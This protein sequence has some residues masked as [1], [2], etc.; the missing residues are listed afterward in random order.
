MLSEFFYGKE[1]NKRL[2]P[3]EAVAYGATIQAAIQMGE[4]SEDVVLLDVCPFSLGIA[5]V[6]KNNIEDE[7]LHM[8]KIINKGSKLPCKKVD[9]FNPACDYST[10]ILIQ[11][12]EGENELVKNNYPL[13]KFEL[14]NLPKKKKEEVK[15]EV[16]FELNEDSILTVT[17]VEKENNSKNSIVIIN[18]RGGLSQNEIEKAKQEQDSTDE[19]KDLGPAM[20]I[21]KNYKY[22]INNLFNKVNKSTIAEEQYKLLKVLERTI[23]N[24]IQTFN[25][26]IS[27]NYTYKQK[28]HYY[29]TYLFNAYSASLNF[30]S[31]IDIET[32]EDIIEKVQNYLNIYEYSGTSYASSLVKIFKDNDDDIFGKFITQVLGYYSQR[33][34]T[35][36]GNNDKK[37]AKHY[38][39][40]AL[41]LE[42]K[43]SL[44]KRLS[45]NIFLSDKLTPI[46][47]NCK[48]FLNTLKADS[49]EKYCQ[50]FSKNIL[51]KEEELQTEE[52]K[53]DM[54][55]RFKDALYYLQ[56]PKNRHDK[57]LKAIYIA[58]IVKI[59]YI[60][61]HSNNYDVL[62][63][64]IEECIDLKSSAPQG[65][66]APILQWFNELCTIKEL[67]ES[68]QEKTKNNPLQAEKMIKEKIK[69]I[70]DEIEEKFK[71]GKIKFLYYILTEHKPIGL[72]KD[73]MFQNAK[74][75]ENAY[76]I[77]EK[78]F[79]KKLR[80]LYS[81][82][83]YKGNK[84]E[85]QKT[86]AI[87]QEISM[88]LNDL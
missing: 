14:I 25:E 8:S 20:I 71:Q 32:K 3:D 13:G 85:E 31:Y 40:E 66:E 39:E 74:E 30:K 23:E 12:Y 5:V 56:N 87:M 76:E 53:I 9:I 57:L 86:H 15:I 41:L 42:K 51:I 77:D 75:L 83:R 67:I 47:D 26:D 49:I 48:E 7:N 61:F 65:C 46:I 29:L 16:T 79:M 52:E 73:L 78:K 68:E 44:S 18:D 34:T 28:M 6:N 88:K 59:E 24:F 84:E 81:P 1:I 45:K 11:V 58:N 63:K 33:G 4:Y 38:I 19:I 70:I 36:Y 37:N 72:D 22:E 17:G 80:K 55:D 54:L 60:M 50:S 64:M 82:V 43:Y 27:D 10:T 2:N 62:L 21:E 69:F 35:Y